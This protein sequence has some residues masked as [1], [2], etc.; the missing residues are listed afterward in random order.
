MLVAS[1]TRLCNGNAVAIAAAAL[2]MGNS[3]PPATRPVAFKKSRRE[4][5]FI[6]AS[7]FGESSSTCLYD[8]CCKWLR[9]ASLSSP[10]VAPLRCDFH[11]P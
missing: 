4:T 10:Y 6:T 2:P 9:K 11:L 5:F 8:L 7:S 1:P 3:S